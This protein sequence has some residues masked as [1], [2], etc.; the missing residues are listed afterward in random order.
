MILWIGH[1]LIKDYFLRMI[2]AKIFGMGNEGK[3]TYIIV[4]KNKMFFQWLS[5]LLYESFEI[6]DVDTV[7][8]ENKKGQWVTKKKRIRDFTDKHETYKGNARVYIFYGKKKVFIT[9]NNT[10]LSNRQKFMKILNEISVWKEAKKK[11]L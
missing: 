8:Y 1:S 4:E 6:Y 9:F 3:F 2:K 10:S 5:K 7:D 11:S